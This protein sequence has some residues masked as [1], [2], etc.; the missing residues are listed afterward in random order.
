MKLGLKRLPAEEI[1][2]VG[3]TFVGGIHFL[4]PIIVLVYLLMVERWSPES[5]VFYSIM[6][7]MVIVVACEGL[8]G[9]YWPRT[10]SVACADSDRCVWMGGDSTS[11][12]IRLTILIAFV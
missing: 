5:S 1:P 10:P 2:P 11:P 8:D 7:M 6:L 3:K 4:I 12:P 9:G